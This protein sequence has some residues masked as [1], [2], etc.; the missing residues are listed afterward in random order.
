MNYFRQNG[1][2][3]I[4]IGRIVDYNLSRLGSWA[5]CDAPTSAIAPYQLRRT[6]LMAG[7]N[8]CNTPV[9]MFRWGSKQCLLWA[10][11]VR[12]RWLG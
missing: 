1:K 5:I 8:D 12:K 2:L 10:Q 3:F 6:V 7:H 9:A 4:A 11:A